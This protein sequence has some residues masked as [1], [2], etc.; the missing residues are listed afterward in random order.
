MLRRAPV[1]RARGF[2]LIELLVT[3]AIFAILAALAVPS[4]NDAILGNKLAGYAN[5]FSASAQLARSEAIKRN[6]TVLM[7][8]SATGSGCDLSGGWQ[9]GWIVWRDANGNS[10]VDEGELIQR[11]QALSSDFHFTG[12]AYSIDFLPTGGAQITGGG[13]PVVLSL[14][15]AL[16]SP[17]GQERDVRVGPTGR[18]SIEKT[19]SGVCA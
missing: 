10:A 15:R 11:R 6:A 12:N 1:A 19:T 13:S 8:R 4:F 17:A 5:S 3:L 18:V 9:Q 2:T 7:C 16:P 14:C